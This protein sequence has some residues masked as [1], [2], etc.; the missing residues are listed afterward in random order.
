MPA[1][2]LQQ[3]VGAAGVINQFPQICAAALA[4]VVQIQDHIPQAFFNQIISKVTIIFQIP[5]RP[6]IA[7]PDLI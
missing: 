1:H 7:A 3:G 5:P 2:G 6:G 4:A